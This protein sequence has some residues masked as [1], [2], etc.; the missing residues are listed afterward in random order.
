MRPNF[1]IAGL[2]VIFGLTLGTQT[3]LGR[4]DDHPSLPDGVG[5]DVMIRVCS[6]C[7][8]PELAA[9]QQFDKAGWKD[10]VDQMASKGA[11]AT[12][13]EFDQIVTYLATAFPPSK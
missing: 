10:L 2:A 11:T 6:Q 5:R 4:G 9:D 3:S 1:L 12:D 13:A 8:D 7:H